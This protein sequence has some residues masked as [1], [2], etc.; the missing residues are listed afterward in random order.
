MTASDEALLDDCR[1]HLVNGDNEKALE[2]ALSAR[3]TSPSNVQAW[4]MAGSACEQMDRF[5][6]AIEYFEGAL[7]LQQTA[8]I[9]N[10]L[11]TCMR[12]SGRGDEFTQRE[13]AVYERLLAGRTYKQFWLEIGNNEPLSGDLC[14]SFFGGRPYMEQGDKWPDCPDCEYS[15]NF[16]C[17][18]RWHPE[19]ND[20]ASAM[21]EEDKWLVSFF[22]CFCR[23]PHRVPASCRIYGSP[24]P[25]KAQKINPAK[26]TFLPALERCEVKQ[27]ASR[28]RVIDGGKVGSVGCIPQPYFDLI[29]LASSWLDTASTTCGL[30]DAV[31]VGGPSTIKGTCKRTTI[32]TLLL[33]IRLTLTYCLTHAGEIEVHEERALPNSTIKYL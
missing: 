29:S 22:Y 7:E 12:L 33:P 15:K 16:V 23:K 8:E 28:R 18:L 11:R 20:P 4:I 9:T 6:D 32:A 2:C 26:T 10:R 31:V 21:K 19:M 30:P 14:S 3:A 24:A 25:D 5:G 1:C 17:Q 13:V 27:K